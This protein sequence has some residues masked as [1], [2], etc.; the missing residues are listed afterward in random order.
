M[1]LAESYTSRPLE[2]T[3]IDAVVAV[4]ES[5]DIEMI[6]E[7]Q[8]EKADLESFWKMPN[9]DLGNDTLGVFDDS[10]LLG[11]AEVLMGKYVEVCVHPDDHGRGIGTALGQWSEDRLRKSGAA[12][13]LQSSPITDKAALQI[14]ADRGYE[15]AWTTWA[16]TLPRDVTITQRAL[17]A[18]YEVRPFVPGVEDEAVYEVVQVAF[19]EWPERE[20]TPYEDWRAL[21]IDREG[22][23]PEKLLVATYGEEIVG[24]CS[25][26]DGERAGWVQNV[27]VDKAHRHHGIAQVLLA[28]AFEGTRSRGLERAELATDSRTG[29]LDLYEK[30]GMQVRQSYEDWILTL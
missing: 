14:F 30:L 25:V 7:P 22:F 17:S 9:F 18:G 6:G 4:A 2:P 26:I 1:D 13:A 29:A 15:K 28:R 21:V 20:R 24:V 27:A 5:Y 11:F 12:K 19:G 10:G 8:I 3:D 16:L 23:G